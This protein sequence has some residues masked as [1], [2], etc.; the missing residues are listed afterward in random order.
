MYSAHSLCLRDD[1]FFPFAFCYSSSA[2][3][4][5]RQK[6]KRSG[7]RKKW[8]IGRGQTDKKQHQARHSFGSQCGKR[9]LLHKYKYVKENEEDEGEI[10][11]SLHTP[12]TNANKKISAVHCTCMQ[13]ACEACVYRNALHIHMFVSV[14]VCVS[15]HQPILVFLSLSLFISL[16]LSRS[17]ALSLSISLVDVHHRHGTRKCL[18]VNDQMFSFCRQSLPSADKPAFKITLW[19]ILHLFIASSQFLVESTSSKKNCNKLKI[20][21]CARTFCSSLVDRNT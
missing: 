13:Y 16:P 4:L 19:Y 3:R 9:K 8:Q 20:A 7:R 6:K 18:Q 15:T 14:C 12:H 1:A 5:G 11:L 10:K 21:W 2:L 17:P